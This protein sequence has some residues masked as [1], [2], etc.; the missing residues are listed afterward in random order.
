[1]VAVDSQD[2]CC[3]QMIIRYRAD[4]KSSQRDGATRR[5]EVTCIQEIKKGT[6]AIVYKGF[7]K[8]GGNLMFLTRLLIM[9]PCIQR[10][11][12]SNLNA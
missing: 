11:L 12:P 10:N 5:D 6:T 7:L 8:P 1:M 9:T 2:R 3:C 4:T